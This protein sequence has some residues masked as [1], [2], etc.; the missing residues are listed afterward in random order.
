ME[1]QSF[2]RNKDIENMIRQAMKHPLPAVMR[3]YL[4]DRE[5]MQ[6]VSGL[7]LE[8]DVIE[9]ILVKIFYDMGIYEVINTKQFEFFRNATLIFLQKAPE[10]NKMDQKLKQEAA[11]R[12]AKQARRES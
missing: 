6:V 2:P 4:Q 3:I 1:R 8:A 9:K 12:K 10:I 5:L 7:D 11:I